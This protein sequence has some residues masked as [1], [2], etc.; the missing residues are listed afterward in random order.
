MER[1]ME[2]HKRKQI[3]KEREREE[4][5][6]TRS[7]SAFEDRRRD[8]VSSCLCRLGLSLLCPRVLSGTAACSFPMVSGWMNLAARY[9]ATLRNKTFH[10]T[11]FT[12]WGSYELAY[13]VIWQCAYWNTFTYYKYLCFQ[14]QTN[15]CI[16]N[17]F[18]HKKSKHVWHNSFDLI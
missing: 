4:K 15:T 2:K 7:E 14:G 8:E 12:P 13:E 5:R 3:M 10:Q 16:L 6:E 17:S 18:S 11:V 1:K 9:F